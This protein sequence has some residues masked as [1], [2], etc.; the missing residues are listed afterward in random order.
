MGYIRKRKRMGYITL[1]SIKRKRE[2]PPK[3]LIL[4]LEI[5]LPEKIIY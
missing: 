2:N 3:L 1:K 5:A 4:T